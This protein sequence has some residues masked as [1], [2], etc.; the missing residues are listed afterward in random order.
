[1]TTKNLA[2]PPAAASPPPHS[3][4]EAV[5]AAPQ[6][7]IAIERHPHGETSTSN[8]RNVDAAELRSRTSRHRATRSNAVYSIVTPF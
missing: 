3:H 6:K 7:V 2:K 4:A 8:A 1:M 5:A